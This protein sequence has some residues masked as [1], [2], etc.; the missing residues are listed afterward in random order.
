MCMH[1]KKTPKKQV[2]S[3]G[4]TGYTNQ[5]RAI[6]GNINILVKYTCTNVYWSYLYDD[7]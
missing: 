2:P 1:S 7:I 5:L 6:F 3:T 4:V